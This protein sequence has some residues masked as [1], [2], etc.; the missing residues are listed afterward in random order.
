[1]C[2]LIEMRAEKAP[3]S[4]HLPENRRRRVVIERGI[5]RLAGE[6]FVPWRPPVSALA[7]NTSR[8]V[9]CLQ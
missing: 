2:V 3:A 1:M 7:H 6:Y 4:P 5:V 8:H 9:R